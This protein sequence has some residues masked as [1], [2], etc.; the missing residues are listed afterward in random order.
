MA[1]A[2]ATYAV[3][4][5]VVN[6]LKNAYAAQRE[7]TQPF[8]FRLISSGELAGSAEPARNALTLFLYRITQ[9]AEARNPAIPGNRIGAIPPLALDLH[10]LLT[11]WADD[12]LMEQTML[13]WAIREI[14]LHPIFDSSTLSS[15]AKW[16]AS[17]AVQIVPAELS[18]D[19]MSRIWGSLSPRYRLSVAYIARVVR[20]DTIR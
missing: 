2:F 19:E 15:Q 12:A 11:A 8:D 1:N 3:S 9:R 6:F 5:S 7:I 10:Y 4:Q 16:A 20:I 13:T 14:Q 18:D 17:D